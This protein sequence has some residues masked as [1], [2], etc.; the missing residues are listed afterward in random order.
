VLNNTIRDLLS[1]GECIESIAVVPVGITKYREGLYPLSPMTKE[2][3]IETLRIVDEFAE[4]T[5]E[6]HG[7]RK[8]YCADEVYIKAGI[9]IPDESYYD[10]YPQLGNGV[11]L[12][13]LL[14]EEFRYALETTEIPEKI[15]EFCVATGVAAAP[16][17]KKL[18]DELREK[19]NNIS[20]AE[21]YPVKN[22]FFGETVDVA[23]LVTGRDL[24]N[25]LKSKKL[26]KRVLIPEV[27]LRHGENIFLDDISIND[28]ERELGVKVIPVENDGEKLLSAMLAI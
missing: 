17:I 2:D 8:V 22:D 14:Q 7:D 28:V 3:A 20:M 18:I 21:V 9:D 11:G 10:G 23:G 19:C 4:E 1:L 25:T 5:K 13:T 6:K 12:I 15:E 16:F 27:M 26:A 24:I